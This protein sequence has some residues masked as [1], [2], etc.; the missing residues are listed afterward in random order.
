MLQTTNITAKSIISKSKLPEVDYCVNPYVGCTH[1]CTYC[2]ARF[3]RRFTGHSEPWGQF[4]DIKTNAAE[5][6]S[7]QLVRGRT[8]SVLIGSVTDAYQPI[9]KRYEITRSMLQVLST[10]DL[11]VSVLTKSALI[12]RDVDIYQKCKDAEIGLTVTSVDDRFG[13]CFEPAAS[14]PSKRLRALEELKQKGLKTYAFIGPI[15]P[16][17]IDISKILDSVANH[18]DYV[19][20]ETLNTRCG[21]WQDI[22]HSLI[23]YGYEGNVDDFKQQVNRKETWDAIEEEFIYLCDKKG[24]K[25]AGFYRH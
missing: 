24:I 17:L 7:R 21:N 14:R 19:M 18:V 5:L 16:G 11:S 25:L 8:G 23:K 3:M 1:G 12:L 2:Y 20:G 6:L 4:L 22:S 10:S 13:A 15:F 9:E